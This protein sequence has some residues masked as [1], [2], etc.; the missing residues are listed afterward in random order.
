MVGLR[1]WCRRER[2]MLGLDDVT[3][4]VALACVLGCGSSVVASMSFSS[5]S[6]TLA[7]LRSQ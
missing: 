6:T 2:Q 5:M 3:A 7:K 1:L 4:V